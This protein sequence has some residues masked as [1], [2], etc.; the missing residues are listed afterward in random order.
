M[1]LV[2]R[3]RRHQPGEISAMSDRQRRLVGLLLLIIGLGVA[4]SQALLASCSGS[5]IAASVSTAAH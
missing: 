1:L 4:S 5:A 3:P 2:R